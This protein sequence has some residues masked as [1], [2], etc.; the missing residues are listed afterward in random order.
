MLFSGP[1]SYSCIGRR[2]ATTMSR[3]KEELHVRIH[4][5]LLLFLFPPV[6]FVL[7]LVL[8]SSCTG[9][10]FSLQGARAVSL[11]REATSRTHQKRTSQA[12][13]LPADRAE[14]GG[15][16]EGS[17]WQPQ[18]DEGPPSQG[19]YN[20]TSTASDSTRVRVEPPS[21]FSEELERMTEIDFRVRAG[22]EP[23]P[24]TAARFSP[25]V[26]SKLDRR[27]VDFVGHLRIYVK[28]RF[29][30]AS[31]PLLA[32]PLGRSVLH[33]AIE[34]QRGLPVDPA[35]HKP[36]PR[37]S[38]SHGH[39]GTDFQRTTSDSRLLWY[40]DSE[41]QFAWQFTFFRPRVSVRM[42]LYNHATVEDHLRTR[43]QMSSLP[44]LHKHRERGS[45]NDT[46]TGAGAPRPQPRRATSTTSAG[47][48][49]SSFFERSVQSI[50]QNYALE[51][52]RSHREAA[53]HAIWRV[54]NDV[55]KSINSTLPEPSPRPAPGIEVHML[56]YEH[57]AALD[58][59]SST[60]P[61]NRL[62]VRL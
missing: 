61:E 48:K 28:K 14:S 47:L 31:L 52:V 3:H 39:T 58:A 6:V 55:E 45:S 8:I 30:P 12:A 1:D 34:V 35:Q 13:N 53:C 54:E 9:G 37:I 25:L 24:G 44:L 36:V 59:A 38:A 51:E 43:G 11:R 56:G 57:V 46:S 10:F 17:G 18:A 4:M 15:E 19:D 29:G 21:L 22:E 42:G 23:P 60:S 2:R 26:S 16:G 20:S 62:G 27:K 5:L 41:G 49:I 50:V 32:L 40:A 33:W 7:F